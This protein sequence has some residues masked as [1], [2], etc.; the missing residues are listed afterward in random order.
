MPMDTVTPL[1]RRWKP[2]MA[3]AGIGYRK[4]S[5]C[6]LKIIVSDIDQNLEGHMSII[7]F[8]YSKVEVVI[9]YQIKDM[10]SPHPSEIEEVKEPLMRIGD[11]AHQA[12]YLITSFLA[13]KWLSNLVQSC[14]Y[15]I[16]E[17]Q[18]SLL[19]LETKQQSFWISFLEEEL[20]ACNLFQ[21][22]GC[23]DLTYKRQSILA[24]ILIHINSEI[25]KDSILIMEEIRLAE[26]IHKTLMGRRYLIVLDDIWDSNVLDE[27][28]TCFPNDGIGSRILVTSRNKDVAPPKIT[29]KLFIRKVIAY[30]SWEIIYLPPTIVKMNNL[31]YVRAESAEYGKDWSISNERNQQPRWWSL[32]KELNNNNGSREMGN[33][34]LRLIISDRT[35]SASE[36]MIKVERECL[37][38]LVESSERTKEEQWDMGNEELISGLSPQLLHLARAYHMFAS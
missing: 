28:L 17:I 24:N 18:R 4:E 9:Q 20:R 10:R 23:L 14:H 26:H 5:I 32:L 3:V 36:I 16:R 6:S 13:Y 22:W 31:R 34:E 27:L 1:N 33:A 19:V 35:A 15:M 30:E 12:K 21:S 29:C 2:I 38:T 37:S 11:I 7:F 25:G 8:C